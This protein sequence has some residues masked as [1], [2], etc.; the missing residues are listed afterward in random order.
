MILA[1]AENGNSMESTYRGMFLGGDLSITSLEWVHTHISGINPLAD[2]YPDRAWTGNA[3]QNPHGSLKEGDS[4][5]MLFFLENGLNS[6][7]KPQWGGRG[8]RF[9]SQKDNLFRDSPDS[10]FNASKSEYHS[11]SLASVYRWRP[12]FL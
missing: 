1:M 8:G 12:D 3:D 9:V 11:S 4:P 2:L 7:A 6:P 10:V 5:S